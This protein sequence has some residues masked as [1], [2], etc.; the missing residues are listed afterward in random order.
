M[1]RTDCPRALDLDP[2]RRIPA[3]W[4][5]EHGEP[6]FHLVSLKIISRDRQG[7]LADVTL[8]ISQCDA[9]ILKA[10]VDISQDNMGVLLFEVSLRDIQHLKEVVEKV[11][12]LDDIVFVE[13]ESVVKTRKAIKHR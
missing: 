10:Q 4:E 11:E 13:R 6:H 1:H 8:A 7:V 3:S 12:S 9:N 5:Q 2:Q